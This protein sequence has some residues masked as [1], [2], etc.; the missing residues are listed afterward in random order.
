[1]GVGCPYPPVRNDVVTPR[2]LHFNLIFS[3]FYERDIDE[4]KDKETLK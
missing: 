1:M 2:H 3:E 4:D